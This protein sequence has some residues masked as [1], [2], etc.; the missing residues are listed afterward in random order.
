MLPM[1]QYSAYL[2][3]C[4]TFLIRQRQKTNAIDI[5]SGKAFAYCSGLLFSLC[6]DPTQC[7]SYIYTKLQPILLWTTFLCENT[8]TDATNTVVQTTLTAVVHFF[9][10][11]KTQDRY[12]HTYT[13]YTHTYIHT[14][15]ALLYLLWSTFL[16]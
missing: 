15:I 6:K 4:S 12:C 9:D 2:Q 14:D 13:L 10:N 8:K 11:S 3:L 7:W 5:Y 1:Y 16:M